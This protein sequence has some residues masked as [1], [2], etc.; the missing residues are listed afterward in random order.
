MLALACRTCINLDRQTESCT[1]QNSNCSGP[2]RG[3]SYC[4]Y[5]GP[6]REGVSDHF[7]KFCF[8]CGSVNLI[9]AVRTNDQKVFGLCE[10][11]KHIFSFSVG[12]EKPVKLRELKVVKDGEIGEF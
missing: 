7:S 11:H 10:T 5:R 8:V 3:K 2:L 4:D 12:G 1:L 9:G 6:L